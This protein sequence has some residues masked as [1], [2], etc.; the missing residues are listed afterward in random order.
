M[1]AAADT[2]PPAPA[3]TE[4]AG[5]PIPDGAQTARIEAPDG[6][7]LR[8][9]YWP[10]E[11]TSHGTVCVFQGRAEF[12]EKYFETVNDLRE[13]GFYV[14]TL[15]WRG[16][17]GSD[18]IAS[19]RNAGHVRRY[20]DYDADL[21]TF[22]R[23][24]VLPDC[25]PPYFALA[26]SMGGLILLRNAVI[27]GTW[28]ERIMCAAPLVGFVEDGTPWKLAIALGRIMRGIGLGR[29]K[30]PSGKYDREAGFPGNLLTS[31]AARYA[32]MLDLTAANPDL[33]LGAPTFGWLAATA[34]AI[35]GVGS[36]AFHKELKIPVLNVAAG[37]DKIVSTPAIEVLGKRM[38]IGNS[39]VLDGARHE[40]LMEQDRIRDRFWAAFD[41]F[42]PGTGE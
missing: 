14:A 20:A 25:P 37:M 4:V 26:H 19:N 27:R 17:G 29:L 38:R 31:D 22:M 33:R 42:I 39:I 16:Q 2:E 15:D 18:R 24:F 40:I 28:F 21:A 34:D 5:N 6:V 7:G 32:R 13:R 41:S 8:A 10:A 3:L 23:E 1:D 30:V 36:E 12:I 11:R 9:A 35:A